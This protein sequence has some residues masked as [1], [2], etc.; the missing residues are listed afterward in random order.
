MFRVCRTSALSPLLCPPSSHCVFF[1]P[2]TLLLF[3]PGG[4]PYLLFP[5]FMRPCIR[6][7]AS[8]R[9]GA[10][11][12]ANSAIHFSALRYHPACRSIISR[13]CA[14][15]DITIN[16]RRA[17]VNPFLF[18]D[19]FNKNAFYNKIHTDKAIGQTHK[20]F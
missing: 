2:S 8:C 17:R 6:A 1:S 3:V 4:S 10:C 9:G 20:L 7:L 15:R 12:T 11:A 13:L 5:A 19:A 14:S 18:R 16:Y